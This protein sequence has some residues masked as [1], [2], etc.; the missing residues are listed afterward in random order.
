[1]SARWYRLAMVVTLALATSGA[2]ACA[3]VPGEA[4]SVTV[5]ASWEPQQREGV[6]RHQDE[7]AHIAA[8]RLADKLRQA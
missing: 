3:A 4:E 8:Y 7:A 6:A 5:M 2:T 1:M